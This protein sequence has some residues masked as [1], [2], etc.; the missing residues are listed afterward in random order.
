MELSRLMSVTWPE[1]VPLG[2][3]VTVREPVWTWGAGGTLIGDG[4]DAFGAIFLALF[5]EGLLVAAVLI[6][7]MRVRDAVLRQVQRVSDRP[8]ILV[9]SVR[10]G[11]E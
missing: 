9:G 1:Q 6:F 2:V 10:H 5:F 3:P 7:H 8:E 4:A 11:D